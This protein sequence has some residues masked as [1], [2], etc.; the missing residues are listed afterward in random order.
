MLVSRNVPKAN[1]RAILDS[2]KWK[3][4]GQLDENGAVIAICRKCVETGRQLAKD[5]AKP[6]NQTYF[7]QSKGY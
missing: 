5:N 2:K 4:L 1:Y 6:E 3:Y 7:K